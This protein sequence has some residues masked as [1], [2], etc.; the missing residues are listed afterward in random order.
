MK[1]GNFW[2]RLKAHRFAYALTILVTLAIGILVGTLV[3]YGVKGQEKGKNASDPAPLEVPS[4]RQLSNT[5]SQV[6]KQL[7]PSVVNINTESTI[8]TPRRRGVRPPG[9][10]YK[11]PSQER[12]A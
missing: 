1:V 5:F 4:P 12:C 7:E 9:G 6:S 10:V 2:A 3:S 8:K 11:D